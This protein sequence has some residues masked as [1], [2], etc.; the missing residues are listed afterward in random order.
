[1]WNSLWFVIPWSDKEW[2][3]CWTVETPGVSNWE[4]HLQLDAFFPHH[5]CGGTRNL[6]PTNAVPCCLPTDAKKAKNDE[7]SSPLVTYGFQFFQFISTFQR[8]VC[9]MLGAIFLSLSKVSMKVTASGLPLNTSQSKRMVEPPIYAWLLWH[10]YFL[11]PLETWWIRY[12]V[13]EN[14]QR[15]LI[16]EPLTAYEIQSQTQVGNSIRSSNCWLPIY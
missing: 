6:W 9:H 13:N 1:M 14:E 16:S 3:R 12:Q 8:E 5:H 15:H 2:Q 4:H 10:G 11:C 7:C